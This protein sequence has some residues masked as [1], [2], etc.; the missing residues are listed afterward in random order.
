MLGWTRGYSTAALDKLLGLLLLA[1]YIV[2]IVGLAAVVTYAVV[3]IFPTE[4]KPKKP[5]E[6]GTPTD[7]T[8][9]GGTLFRRSKRANA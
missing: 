1:L 4:R 5:D 2:V 8:T 3:R 6:P 9:S 7:G